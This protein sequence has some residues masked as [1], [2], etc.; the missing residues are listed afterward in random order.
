[1]SWYL[2]LVLSLVIIHALNNSSNIKIEVAWEAGVRTRP[3]SSVVD[4]FQ[5]RQQMP[6]LLTGLNDSEVW[7]ELAVTNGLG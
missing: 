1:M 5:P 7:E 4:M 2:C 6:V 3:V